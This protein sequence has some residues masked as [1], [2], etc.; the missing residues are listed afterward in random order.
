[1]ITYNDY[2]SGWL[3]LSV[4]DWLEKFPTT[5]E[6]LK[7]SL[8]T[9]VDSNK[10]PASLVQTSPEL[11]LLRPDAR[12]LGQ[13]LLVPTRKVLEANQ[14]RRIFFG[15]DEI[16]FFP[17]EPSF[18]KPDTAWLVGPARVEHRT[19]D[20]LGR[21]MTDNSCPLALGD[22]TGLN[23]VVKARGLVKYLVGISR[24]QPSIDEIF[25]SIEYEE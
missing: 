11:E 15:F 12:P 25:D 18:P 24:Y 5:Y 9:C 19:L 17:S 7:Y 8:I 10:N 3:N 14:N 20:A 21:W 6:K 13:G 16:W 23:L 1:M 4:S 22:G 2:V